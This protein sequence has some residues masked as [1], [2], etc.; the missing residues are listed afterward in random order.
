MRIGQA[1]NTVLIAE[2][3]LDDQR[4]AEGQQQP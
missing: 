2:Q 1:G 4:Q 3:A